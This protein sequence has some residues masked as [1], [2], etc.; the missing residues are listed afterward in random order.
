MIPLAKLFMKTVSAAS[1]WTFVNAG[2]WLDL[3]STDVKVPIYWFSLS[4]CIL[5]PRN[6]F[7]LVKDGRTKSFSCEGQ[8]SCWFNFLNSLPCCFR[9]RNSV[10][11]FSIL[12]PS[13]LG[14]SSN[15]GPHV[16]CHLC[17]SSNVFKVLAFA[18]ITGEVFP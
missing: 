18:L 6:G 7:L 12:W 8:I 2:L 13:L 17:S 16:C 11:W 14:N 4:L 1:F 10:S 5:S 3:G 9:R 15:I